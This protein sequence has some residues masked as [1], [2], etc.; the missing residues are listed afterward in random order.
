MTVAL[1]SIKKIASAS[2]MSAWVQ[3]MWFGTRHGEYQALPSTLL[4]SKSDNAEDL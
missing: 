1:Q 2:A 3:E 4:S